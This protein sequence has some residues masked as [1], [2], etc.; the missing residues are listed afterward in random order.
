MFQDYL[1]GCKSNMN[2]WSDILIEEWRAI[3]GYEGYQEDFKNE[4]KN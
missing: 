1:L 4:E 3:P 2:D